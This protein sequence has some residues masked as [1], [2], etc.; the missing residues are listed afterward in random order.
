[1]KFF[2]LLNHDFCQR[3]MLLFVPERAYPEACEKEA[4]HAVGPAEEG[5]ALGSLPM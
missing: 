2:I 3:F 5:M 4:E 1:M